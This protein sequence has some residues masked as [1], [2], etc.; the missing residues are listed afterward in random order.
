MYIIMSFANSDSFT[1]SFLIWIPF[2]SFSSLTAVAETSKTML[3]K[4]GESRYL[5][6]V[7]DLRREASS[8]SPL[9]IMLAVGFYRCSLSSSPLFLFFWEFCHKFQIHFGKYFFF[10]GGYNVIFLWFVNYTDFGG[11]HWLILNIESAL[12]PC[13]KS[14]G[15]KFFYIFICLFI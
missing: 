7:P 9:S 8:I 13:N 12:Y 5:S 1:S 14:H 10:I 2:I 11:L 15:I 3:N 6:L 4:T